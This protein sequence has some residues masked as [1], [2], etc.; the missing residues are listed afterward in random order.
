MGGAVGMVESVAQSALIHASSCSLVRR[1]LMF[2]RPMPEFRFQFGSNAAFLSLGCFVL[3]NNIASF[4]YFAE[5]PGHL[6]GD[7]CNERGICDSSVG[8][9]CSAGR[10]RACPPAC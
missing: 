8:T 4:S 9:C 6:G 3:C 2:C 10:F 1:A 5:S 7:S